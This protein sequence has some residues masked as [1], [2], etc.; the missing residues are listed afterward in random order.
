MVIHF[1]FRKKCILYI[2]GNREESFSK[3]KQ[4]PNEQSIAFLCALKLSTN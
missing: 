2:V 4:C 3:R 1:N